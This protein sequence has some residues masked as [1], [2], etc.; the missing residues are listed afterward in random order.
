MKK[1][2]ARLEDLTPEAHLLWLVSR[3]NCSRNLPGGGNTGFALRN[4]WISSN[5][6]S[7]PLRRDHLAADTK[8][9]CTSVSRLT[10]TPGLKDAKMTLFMLPD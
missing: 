9:G 2:V 7:P 5:S 8:G 10:Y 4:S 1:F 6:Q 3:R